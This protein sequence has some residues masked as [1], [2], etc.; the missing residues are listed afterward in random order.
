MGK[1]YLIVLP[2]GLKDFVVERLQGNVK[3]QGLNLVLL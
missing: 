3:Y 1:S 2:A